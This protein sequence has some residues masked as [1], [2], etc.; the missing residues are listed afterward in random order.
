MKKL[1]LLSSFCIVL[2]GCSSS[3]QTANQFRSDCGFFELQG[4]KPLTFE[5]ISPNE[6]SLDGVICSGSLNAFEDMLEAYP[7]VNRFLIDIIEGS[8][9]DETNLQLSKQIHDKGIST[10][11]NANGMIAS[12]GVDL[13]LAGVERTASDNEPQ[14][15]VHS[16]GSSDGEDGRQ[17]AKSDPVHQE[18]LSYY[19]HI[20]I[21]PQFYWF[22][23]QAAPASDIHWMNQSELVK[24][25]VLSH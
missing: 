15:G 13:F 7:A 25:K 19:R 21:N 9:D 18:Y 22:T 5:M 2:S 20:G 1:I 12:G 8:S 4:D 17:V 24:Y 23:L 11:L 6:A 14:I 16:W 10:H 3:D